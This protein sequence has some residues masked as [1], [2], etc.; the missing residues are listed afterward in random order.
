LRNLD[1]RL[2]RAIN[3]FADRTSWAHGTIAAYAKAGIVVFAALLLAGW[4]TARSADGPDQMARVLWAGAGALVALGVNQVV[5][6]LVD[7]ARPYETLADVHVLIARTTD[8]SF[9]SDHAVTVGAVAT[10]LFLANRRL[11]VLTGVLALLMAAA[12]VYVGAHYPGDVVA[13]LLLGAVVVAV[14]GLAGIPLLRA[15]VQLVA[16]SPLRPL[17]SAPE[18]EP[19]DDEQQRHKNADGRAG[20]S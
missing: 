15:T 1:A 6:G 12:R 11:G 14:G 13:G 17:I 16:R 10:G 7:R 9:P 5:G 2:F 20:S 4:W 8:F 18:P 19:A 3:H